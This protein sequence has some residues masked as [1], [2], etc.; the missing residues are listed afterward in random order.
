VLLE[1]LALTVEQEQPGDVGLRRR[2][3]G[4]Y[5]MPGLPGMKAALTKHESPYRHLVDALEALVRDDLAAS[6]GV[7]AWTPARLADT[8]QEAS[9]NP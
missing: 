5:L 9:A 6:E 4:R 7:P 8:G 2:F 3:L 1:F